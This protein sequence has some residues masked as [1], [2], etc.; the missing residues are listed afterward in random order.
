MS[1][2]AM[3]YAMEAMVLM[4]GVSGGNVFGSGIDCCKRFCWFTSLTD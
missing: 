2:Q 4:A 1:G 3:L